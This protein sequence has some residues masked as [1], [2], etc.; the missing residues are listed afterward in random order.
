MY[1]AMDRPVK[2]VD[3]P[4]SCADCLTLCADGPNCSFRVCA[5][6]D[7]SGV[8]FSISALKTIPAAAGPDG[9]CSR[10]DGPAVHKSTSFPRFA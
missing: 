9:P 7:G 6:R 2:Y 10:A 3:R 1:S 5:G 4:A 8:D